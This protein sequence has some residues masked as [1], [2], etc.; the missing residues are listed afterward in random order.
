MNSIW[1]KR[2]IGLMILVPLMLLVAIAA[3]KFG[4][5]PARSVTAEPASNQLVAKPTPTLMDSN[6]AS[7]SQVLELFGMYQTAVGN[8][9][10]ASTVNDYLDSLEKLYRERGYVPLQN[11]NVPH[12]KKTRKS[13]S[14][15]AQPGGPVKFFQRDE[16]DGVASISATGEDAD[17]NSTE[18]AAEPYLFSTL[19][20][21]AAAGGADWATYRV[22]L[23]REKLARLQ[24]LDRDDFP[25]V[26]PEG[27]PRLPGLQRLYVLSSGNGS[28]AIYKSQE[29][30]PNALMAQYLEEM[31]R[32]GWRLDSPATSAANQVAAGVL[33]FTQGERSSL[34]W[35]TPNKQ[36]RTTNITIS[37]R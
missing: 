14:A 18:S 19:V 32:H 30:A 24:H 10:V 26:D 28:L 1:R 22:G 13:R 17:F 35:V 37:S 27:V 2:L 20:V 7:K 25:G 31:P 4:P 33:C 12:P 29:P 11:L 5:S 9:R 23:D 34:I 8:G 15:A 16:T 6:T 36:N 21:P 3:Y